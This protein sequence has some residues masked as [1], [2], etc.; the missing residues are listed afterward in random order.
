L[1][2]VDL[3]ENAGVKMYKIPSGE[4]TNLPL[5]EKVARTGKRIFLSSGMSNYSEL[6][7]AVNTILEYN[8][9]LTVMQCSSQYPCPYEEAGLNVIQQL[10]QR[11]SCPVGFSDHTPGVAASFAA[12]VL[13][14][15]V[16]EKHFT[17]SKKL[18]GPDSKN[19]LKPEE[20]KHLVDGIRQIEIMLNHPVDKDDLT[21]YHDM[22]HIF[23]KSIVSSMDIP[24]GTIIKPEMIALKKPGG[25][26]SPKNYNIII[27]K[28]VNKDIPKNTQLSNEDIN[29]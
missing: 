3:L 5:L 10:K 13:G 7:E 18:Y 11:Y 23:Q 1:E 16:I 17:L 29:W 24:A 19:S 8:S 6:D 26:L 14:A 12:V 28:I 2:A 20:F 21:K 15:T 25:G 4:I 9:D 22:K 27:G